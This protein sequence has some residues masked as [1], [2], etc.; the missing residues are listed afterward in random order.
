MIRGIHHVALHTAN[1]DAM[2]AFYGRAFGFHPVAEQT[3]WRDEPRIDALIGVPGSSA[4]TVM[5]SA[6]NCYLELFEYFSPPGRK[7]PP[8]N[9]NDRGY[10]HFCVDVVDIR[11]E[12]ERLRE[13][14][15]RFPEDAPGD[16]G[17][18]QMIYGRDPDGNVIEIQ[19]VVSDF[20]FAMEKLE[21]VRLP[22]E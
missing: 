16:L 6:G 12:F 21:N 4:R 7:D 18:V 19:E 2:V 15:M 22:A 10:T 17:P 1:F 20:C 9:P 11:H 13:A 8:L 14:G 3:R 5:L